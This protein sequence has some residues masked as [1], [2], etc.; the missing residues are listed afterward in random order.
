MRN[1]N[2]VPPQLHWRSGREPDS[3]L[4]P[5]CVVRQ[6]PSSRRWP[7]KGCA[8]TFSGR[9]EHRDLLFSLTRG[10]GRIVE[11][12]WT[13]IL[14]IYFLPPFYQRQRR[15]RRGH[16]RL[17]NVA[18]SSAQRESPQRKVTLGE[19]KGWWPCETFSPLAEMLAGAA[20]CPLSGPCEEGFPWGS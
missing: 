5:P 1:F 12:V 16:Y 8:V 19:D 15:G 13:L 3:L 2:L 6:S 10:G 4:P 18:A 20:S 11:L 9:Q 17:S 7:P 14:F